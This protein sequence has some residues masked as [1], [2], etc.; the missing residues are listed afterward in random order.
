M[1][2]LPLREATHGL[3]NRWPSHQPALAAAMQL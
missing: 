1:G 3:S 2:G